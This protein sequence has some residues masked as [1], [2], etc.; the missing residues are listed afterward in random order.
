MQNLPREFYPFPRG[1]G[2]TKLGDGHAGVV[3]SALPCEAT[4]MGVNL[5]ADRIRIDSCETGILTGNAQADSI[6]ALSNLTGTKN[7]TPGDGQSHAIYVGVCAAL[8]LSGST[9]SDTNVGHLV[10]SRAAKTV[11][12]DCK[13]DKVRASR[14]IDLCN[15]GVFVLDGYSTLI[16]STVAQSYQLIG[17]GTELP[18]DTRG[19]AV[20]KYPL[21]T[22]TVAPS[23]TYFGRDIREL[24]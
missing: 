12:T 19:W 6:V 5:T 13:L 18:R 1:S 22:F 4:T 24:T 14:C 9:I 23:V 2:S 17:Y 10:K 16:N 20:A 3:A 21:N 8:Y 15:G 7:G 11:I